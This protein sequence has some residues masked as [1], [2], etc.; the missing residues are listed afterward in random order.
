MEATK[1]LKFFNAII[2]DSNFIRLNFDWISKLS[3]LNSSIDNEVKA[4]NCYNYFYSTRIR[5]LVSYIQPSI[6]NI[7]KF[8][9]SRRSSCLISYISKNIEHESIC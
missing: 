1:I 8:K 4:V 2:H 7:R 9:I 5:V 3:K 6:D